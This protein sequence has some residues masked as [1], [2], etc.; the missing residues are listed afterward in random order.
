MFKC[1]KGYLL[2]SCIVEPSIKIS[3][4][5]KISINL[6]KQ[7]IVHLGRTNYYSNGCDITHLFCFAFFYHF[8][9]LVQLYIR[10]IEKIPRD[11]R[12]VL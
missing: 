4:S 2:N 5:T 9:R 3:V 6:N 10:K 1:L 11:N 8:T 7:N 12:V